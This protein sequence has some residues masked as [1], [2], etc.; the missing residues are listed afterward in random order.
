MDKESKSPLEK[1]KEFV[2]PKST[3]GLLRDRKKNIDDEI[4]SPGGDEDATSYGAK[5][6][7]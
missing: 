1:L 4:D 5:R 2:S 6:K 7:K 3:V